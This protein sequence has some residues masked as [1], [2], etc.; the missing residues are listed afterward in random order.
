MSK[1]DYPLTHSKFLKID[2]ELYSLIQKTLDIDYNL[3]ENPK[4][5]NWYCIVRDRL[6]QQISDKKLE[7]K[8]KENK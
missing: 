7:L 3:N 8:R 1:I 5:F 6:C 4:L 2:D